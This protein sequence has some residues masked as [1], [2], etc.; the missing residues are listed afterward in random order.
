MGVAAV[1]SPIGFP[2]IGNDRF[3]M[4]VFSPQGSDECVLS[5]DRE[6]LGACLTPKPD[7]V[8]SG[9][10]WLRLCCLRRSRSGQSGVLFHDA[11]GDAR[12]AA[13]ERRGA[14][15]VIVAAGMDD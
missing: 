8:F 6:H 1:A 2:D 4:L 12:P 3:G 11:T 14:V 13:A 10:D 9:H 5:L 15:G 7:G